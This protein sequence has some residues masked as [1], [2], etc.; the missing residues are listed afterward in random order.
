MMDG[1]DKETYDDSVLGLV[2]GC[3]AQTYAAGEEQFM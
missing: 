1:I 2:V 3:E